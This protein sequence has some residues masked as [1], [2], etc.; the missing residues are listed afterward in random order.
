VYIALRDINEK[1]V[2]IEERQNTCHDDS[3]KHCSLTCVNLIGHA[4]Y[5][6]TQLA[7]QCPR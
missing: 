5:H 3:V 7:E 2:E 4:Q 1:G 6:Q